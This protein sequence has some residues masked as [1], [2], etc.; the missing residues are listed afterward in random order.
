VISGGA[1]N[2]G[3]RVPAGNGGVHVSTGNGVS[4]VPTGNV[5]STVPTGNVGGP[6]PTGNVSGTVPSGKVG[7]TVPTGNVGSIAV[8]H[9]RGV[10]GRIGQGSSDNPCKPTTRVNNLARF[11]GALPPRHGGGQQWR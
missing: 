7:G 8:D 9:G 6:T 4:T 10:I 3:V 1:L 5:G 2:G 11:S